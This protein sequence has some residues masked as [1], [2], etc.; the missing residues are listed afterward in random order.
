M[1]AVLVLVD[2]HRRGLDVWSSMII[3][4]EVR[5]HLA[6]TTATACCHTHHDNSPPGNRRYKPRK[7]EQGKE[8]GEQSRAKQSKAELLGLNVKWKTM[9]TEPN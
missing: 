1:W 4:R 8:G 3:G 7:E 2:G 9:T 5:N 6:S